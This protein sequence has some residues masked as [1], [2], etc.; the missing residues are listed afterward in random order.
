MN[1]KQC[2]IRLLNEWEWV[3]Y[4][5]CTLTKC[6]LV[7]RDPSWHVPLKACYH[8]LLQETLSWLYQLYEKVKHKSDLPRCRD[9]GETE[10]IGPP[11]SKFL[12]KKNVFLI[13]QYLK[14]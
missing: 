2:V 4:Y 6:C 3:T 7:T 14:E 11:Y 9:I 10:G 12:P 1:M 5:T 13:L 8:K